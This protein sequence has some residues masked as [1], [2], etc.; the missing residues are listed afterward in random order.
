[1]T[2]SYWQ[3]RW[4]SIDVFSQEILSLCQVWSWRS[5]IQSK[6]PC[7]GS[8]LTFTAG[9]TGEA[10]TPC[11]AVG[12]RV[13]CVEVISLP[14]SGPP[15]QGWCFHIWIVHTVWTPAQRQ[16]LRRC[17][18]NV[19]SYVFPFSPHCVNIMPLPPTS[20]KGKSFP[21]NTLVPSTRVYKKNWE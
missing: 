6:L 13:L 20:E 8:L 1:M 14:S 18:R 10:S 19:F 12:R 2:K 21:Q 4:N 9:F 17:P 5:G 3:F 11:S 15:G 16:E 7:A